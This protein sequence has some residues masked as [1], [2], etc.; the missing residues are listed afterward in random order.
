MSLFF[1]Y[2]DKTMFLKEEETFRLPFWCCCSSG[3][4]LLCTG[5]RVRRDI[6]YR[7][8]LES[9]TRLPF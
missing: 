7:R 3:L 2:S 6:G 4:L 5:F 9:R 8:S 1:G